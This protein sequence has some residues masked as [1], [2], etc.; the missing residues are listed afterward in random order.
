[1]WE[2]ELWRPPCDVLSIVPTALV[3]SL[4]VMGPWSF[5]N[6]IIDTSLAL[7]SLPDA[8][9]YSSV[10]DSHGNAMNWR[11]HLSLIMRK[12]RLGE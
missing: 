2:L 4:S 5:H 9:P 12:L 11:D 7:K 1:M 3:A 6:D 10:F 8:L